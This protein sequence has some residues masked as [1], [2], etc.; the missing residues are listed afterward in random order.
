[1]KAIVVRRHGGPNVLQV[2]EVPIP[3]LQPGHV[4]VKNAAIGVNFV[5][6]QHRAGVNYQ[7]TLPLIIGTEAAGVV[8]AIGPNGAA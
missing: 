6:I 8:T 3:Q 1:L 4:L 5:D 2:E 7:V